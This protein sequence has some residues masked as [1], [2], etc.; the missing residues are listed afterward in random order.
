MHLLPDLVEYDETEGYCLEQDPTN[1]LN[2]GFRYRDPS[3]GTFLTRDPLGFKAGPNMYTYV[4]MRQP[5]AGVCQLCQNKGRDKLLEYRGRVRTACPHP[6]GRLNTRATH[7]QCSSPPTTGIDRIDR[8]P[9]AIC[10]RLALPTSSSP[11]G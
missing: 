5:I 11:A 2:E 6:S 10:K 1:L 4:R 3:T 7:I 8:Q 9:M